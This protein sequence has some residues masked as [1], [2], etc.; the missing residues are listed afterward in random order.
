[1]ADHTHCREIV[2]LDVSN[3]SPITDFLVIA[4][5]TSATQMKAVCTEI[6]EMGR[7]TQ[8]K[9]LHQTGMEGESWMVQDFIDVVVHVFSQAARQYYD[10]ENLWGD[11]KKVEWKS[12]SSSI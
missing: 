3:I 8:F 9:P 6:E 4:T 10:L 7:P 1:M 2:V 5:G 12:P 11:A